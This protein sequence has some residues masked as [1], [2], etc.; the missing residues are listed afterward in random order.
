M[1]ETPK[2]ILGMKGQH[3]LMLVIPFLAA[4]MLAVALFLRSGRDDPYERERAELEKLVK[5]RRRQAGP[6]N[7][8]EALDNFRRAQAQ[9]SAGSL[10]A[11][12]DAHAAREG[13]LKL[14]DSAIQVLR[15]AIFDAG[16]PALFRLELIAVTGD[17]KGTE[18]ESLLVAVMS[19]RSLEERFR[20]LALARLSGR[21][22]E[23]LFTA[24]RALYSE[25][26]EYPA[27]NLVLRAIG[28][29]TREEV[30]SILVEASRKEKT[31]SARIQAVDSLGK[32]ISE[33]RVL[34]A[35]R[36]ALV[37]D[38]QENVRLAAIA[39]LGK[40]NDPVARQTLREIADSPQ[41]SPSLRKAAQNQIDARGSKQ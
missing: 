26:P 10:Q 5:D 39:S 31:A 8:A 11:P 21:T 6:V 1:E 19:D 3:V 2:K 16:E 4:V 41:A 23:A 13:L 24:L 29:F 12:V 7:P 37:Q 28:E 25:E 20:T 27:R 33:S 34:D 15:K 22:S 32:R 30:T 18:A 38:P 36:E 35:V 17:M 40:S 9:S 14:G